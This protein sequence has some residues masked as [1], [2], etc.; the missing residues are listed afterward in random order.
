MR[1][2]TLSR[3]MTAAFGVLAAC[4]AGAANPQANLQQNYENVDVATHYL[5]RL[6]E[7]T[8]SFDDLRLMWHD[9]NGGVVPKNEKELAAQYLAFL[10]TM[11]GTHVTSNNTYMPN[12]P[13]Y[14]FSYVED[15]LEQENWNHFVDCVTGN[16]RTK[17]QITLWYAGVGTNIDQQAFYFLYPKKNPS[18]W[19]VDFQ[20]VDTLRTNFLA[21]SKK[22]PKL[23]QYLNDQMSEYHPYVFARLA[24]GN[25]ALACVN[26][27]AEV[28]KQ[29]YAADVYNANP[30]NQAKGQTYQYQFSETPPIAWKMFPN[31][32]NANDFTK[33][34]ADYSY[35][36][37]K[38]I[39]PDLFYKK[40]K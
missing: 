28:M 17:T 30:L 20:S 12:T 11:W 23:D 25:R 40:K 26:R 16:P 36:N 29:T 1:M 2:K 27:H 39:N 8:V 5:T 4:S 38:R 7:S 22:F 9:I 10:R 18:A 19:G 3:I 13:K 31:Y 37:A 33:Y 24:I 34:V 21:M 35:K 6:L 32:L 14:V 15:L